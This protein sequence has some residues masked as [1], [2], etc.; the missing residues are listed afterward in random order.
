MIDIARVMQ[1]GNLSVLLWCFQLKCIA[2]CCEAYN[3]KVAIHLWQVGVF[4]TLP[5]LKHPLTH[6]FRVAL[7]KR[8]VHHRAL[9]QSPGRWRPDPAP[10]TLWNSGAGE[11]IS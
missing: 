3:L 4:A 1:G 5:V 7:V 8:G 11:W 6:L 9:R 2:R 10:A